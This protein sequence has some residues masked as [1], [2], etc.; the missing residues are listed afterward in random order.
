V[1]CS[2]LVL[3]LPLG[4]CRNTDV[5]GLF[6]WPVSCPEASPGGL[7]LAS[8]FW[9]SSFFRIVPQPVPQSRSDLVNRVF[10]LSQITFLNRVLR[11]FLG[12]LYPLFPCLNDLQV[13]VGWVGQD[14]FLFV[15]VLFVS[16]TLSRVAF[17]VLVAR[18]SGEVPPLMLIES[19]A[20]SRCLSAGDEISIPPLLCDAPGFLNFFLV[21]LFFFDNFFV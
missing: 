6:S 3:F 16:I 9:F 14:G 8:S 20:T 19:S 21:G 13:K 11:V 1:P 5:G 10:C 18:I 7:F 17:L 4:G 15:F 2:L 12:E